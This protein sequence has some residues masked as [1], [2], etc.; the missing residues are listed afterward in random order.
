MGRKTETYAQNQ[1]AAQEEIHAGIE[2]SWKKNAVLA[3]L[4]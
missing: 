4:L 1:S 3:N 2:P